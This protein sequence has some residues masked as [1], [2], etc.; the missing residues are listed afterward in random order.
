LRL[1]LLLATLGWLL[2]AIGRDGLLAGLHSLLAAFGQ[3]RDRL[4]VRLMLALEYVDGDERP[5]SWRD[6]LDGRAVPGPERLHLSVPQLRSVDR[7]ALA[8]LMATAVGA[9]LA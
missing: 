7:W 3:H 1:T 4:V 8:V 9:L 2:A 5:R 6:W